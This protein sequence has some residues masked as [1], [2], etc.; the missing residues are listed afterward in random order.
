MNATVARWLGRG[1]AC[2]MAIACSA[3]IAGIQPSE[4][5]LKGY[6]SAS[7]SP[8]PF[9][10][11]AS[12]VA[13][14]AT[15]PTARRPTAELPDFVVNARIASVSPAPAAGNVI[16]VTAD[17][18]TSTPTTLRTL[19]QQLQ[20]TVDGEL[21]ESV[22]PPSPAPATSAE[23]S[24][25]AKAQSAGRAQSS[26]STDQVL[27]VSQVMLSVRTP[28]TFAPRLDEATVSLYSRLDG[29]MVASTAVKI[30]API[31]LPIDDT[32]PFEAWTKDPRTVV[33]ALSAFAA[34]GAVLWTLLRRRS[35]AQVLQ[36]ATLSN[37]RAL[38]E[39]KRTVSALQ[40]FKP[41][42]EEQKPAALLLPKSLEE[43]AIEE[44][45]AIVLGS[46][47]SAQAGLPT[48][49]SIADQVLTK[50]Q[51][52]GFI[53]ADDADGLRVL[54]TRA[55][56]HALFD[57]LVA[58]VPPPQIVELIAADLPSPRTVSVLHEQ[59]M[60][61][62]VNVFIDLTWDD[63]APEALRRLGAQV[64][65][66]N[67]SDKLTQALRERRVCL[68]KP[69]GRIGDPDSVCLTMTDLR[70]RLDRNPEY[71][72]LLS[73][74]L[75]THSVLFVG[76]DIRTIGAFLGVL[77]PV[78]APSRRENIAVVPRHPDDHLWE[79]SVGAAYGIKLAS[80]VPDPTF[81]AIPAAVHALANTVDAALRERKKESFIQ[82]VL[83][84]IHLVN[85]GVYEKVSI[86]VHEDWTVFLGMN[87]GGKSTILRAVALAMSGTDDRANAPAQRLLRRSAQA[88]QVTLEFNDK[89]VVTTELVRTS[90]GVE[91][92]GS[93]NS[94]LLLRRMLVLGFPVLRGV[95]TK[96]PSG[97]QALAISDPSVSDV[98]PLLAGAADSRLDDMKQWLVNVTVAAERG[99]AREKRMLATAERI[100]QAMLP[101]E[102]VTL[103]G[104]DSKSYAVLVKT[105]DGVVEFDALS[106]GMGSIFNWVGVLVRRL[107]DI[108]PNSKQPEREH[109]LVLIDELDAHLHPQ[110]QRQLVS[111]ARQEF[112]NV[113]IVATTHS[114]LLVGALKP[115]EIRVVER[116]EATGQM[117]VRCPDI[118]LQGGSVEQILTSPLFDLGSTREPD[119]EVI[120]KR[121]LEL[122]ERELL[123]NET[124]RAELEALRPQ[125][126]RLRFGVVAK[127]AP[128]PVLEPGNPV[129]E[130]LAQ[131]LSGKPLMPVADSGARRG[132]AS[133]SEAP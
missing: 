89:D 98:E 63:A 81:A 16:V 88:G 38:E 72:R 36:N 51:Q 59:L 132:D 18:I 69:F 110:W 86:E 83:K 122:Y 108:Y 100:V 80:F 66:P 65:T 54:A 127:P 33:T 39:A 27:P 19:A 11:P 24:Y 45:L 117:V 106:Q 22:L 34:M 92:R 115:D 73:S 85:I 21:A 70:R 79:L 53:N 99:A 94:P 75:S 32:S 26:R 116:D 131:L 44:R 47:A 3:A 35:D 107:Y 102:D 25:A 125:F 120:I 52:R 14:P 37:H 13:T 8:L 20:V 41:P 49:Y 23:G 30:A 128:M 60:R 76:A 40:G 105:R 62:H 57:A 55:G 46:G 124:E 9:A 91:V 109:A 77:P 78:E 95:T 50:L 64:F 103:A 1:V 74:F 12:S 15:E 123:L 43:A 114:A 119:A 56:A 48:T 61:L 2:G 4:D 96:N 82:P 67:E 113:Q 29:R 97:A 28:K 112:P 10:L 5:R 84:R 130:A 7:A 58:R 104:Y 71:A 121:Y 129:A 93:R 31:A 118:D 6:P 126:E 111:L 42:P 87:G 133:V 68:L 90:D 17:V 101:G